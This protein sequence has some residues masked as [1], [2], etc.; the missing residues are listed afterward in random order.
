MT[1]TNNATDAN[2]L[3]DTT[4]DDG[5][6][7]FMPVN[8]MVDLYTRLEQ[9]EDLQLDWKCPGRRAPPKKGNDQPESTAGNDQAQGT[10]DDLESMDQTNTEFDFD[11]DQFSE[12]T[13]EKLSLKKRE[14]QT[15]EKKTSLIDIMSGMRK[16]KETDSL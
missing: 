9:G 11:E 2:K 3:I 13:T 14:D 12:S 7:D 10:G 1:T 6:F 8:E 5:I 4:I 16:Q 15:N